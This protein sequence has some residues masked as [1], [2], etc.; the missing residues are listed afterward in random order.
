[1]A[2]SAHHCHLRAPAMDVGFRF[3]FLHP[4]DQLASAAHA[5]SSQRREAARRSPTNLTCCVVAAFSFVEHLLWLRCCCLVE[6]LDSK[7]NSIA[8]ASPFVFV[9]FS[10]KPK[11]GLTISFV[12]ALVGVIEIV[13]TQS[14]Y[15][16]LKVFK[17]HICTLLA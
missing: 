12:R 9:A 1:M 8:A 10:S 15:G 5:A 7:P 14:R 6:H 3:V 2:A 4:N 13:H 17:V 16:L 11:R